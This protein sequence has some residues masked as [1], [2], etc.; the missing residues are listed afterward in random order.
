[1]DAAEPMDGQRVEFC[2]NGFCGINEILTTRRISVLG[3]AK[4]RIFRRAEEEL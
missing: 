4:S 1:M 3:R 2:A